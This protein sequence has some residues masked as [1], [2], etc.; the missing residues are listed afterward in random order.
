MSLAPYSKAIATLLSTAA[1]GVTTAL[2]L[3]SPGDGLITSAEWISIA[4]TTVLAT[5]AVF[6]APANRPA[7]DP[8]A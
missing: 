7:E 4:A 8:G 2:L 5:V 6:L 3:G 1:A